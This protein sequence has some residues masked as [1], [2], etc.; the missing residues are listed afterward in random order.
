[1]VADIRRVEISLGDGIKRVAESER[2]NREIARKSLVA[3]FSNWSRGKVDAW[4]MSLQ[5]GL[6]A[7][8]LQFSIGMFWGAPPLGHSTKMSL[9]TYDVQD[10]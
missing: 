6:V 5:K 1:M 8:W 10:N 4:G 7:G 3:S 2:K 9:L